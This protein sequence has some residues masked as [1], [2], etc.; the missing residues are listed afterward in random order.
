VLESSLYYYFFNST[1]TICCVNDE[2][3]IFALEFFNSNEYSFEKNQQM[4]WTFQKAVMLATFPDISAEKKVSVDVPNEISG[5]RHLAQTM[6][7]CRRESRK[8]RRRRRQQGNRNRCLA[9]TFYC[10]FSRLTLVH[11]FFFSFY[12]IIQRKWSRGHLPTSSGRDSVATVTI[13]AFQIRNM[14]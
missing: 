1:N 4:L 6:K 14:R 11:Y 2:R 10:V 5:K 13:T 9:L 12:F 8:K 7:Y 3:Y